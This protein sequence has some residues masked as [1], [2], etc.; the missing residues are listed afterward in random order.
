M[1]FI[2][3]NRNP[4]YDI[5]KD[6]VVRAISTATGESYYDTESMLEGV[7]Y[8][9]DCEELEVGCYSYL[10]EEILGYDV[11]GGNG[12]KVSSIIEDHPNDILLIRVSGH[13]TCAMFGDLYDI[14]DCG[15][16]IVDRYWVVE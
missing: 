4:E 8:C 5:E 14:W 15:D 3:Y 6:C 7:G 13:L 10:L 16:E 2:F 12:R 9:Y 1:A 11:Y